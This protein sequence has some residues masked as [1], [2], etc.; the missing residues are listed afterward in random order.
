MAKLARISILFL[1]G[2]GLCLVGALGAGEAKPGEK[3]MTRTMKESQLWTPEELKWADVADL[4]GAKEA[5][6]WGDPKKG[7]YASF[8][9]WPAG[10]EVPL[11]WHTHDNRGTVISG[12]LSIS[13]DGGPA[14]E[15]GPGSYLFVPGGVKHATACKAGAD[16]VFYAHQPGIADLKMVEAAKK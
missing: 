5:V 4:P 16:C 6:V 7:A 13:M 8:N 12:T 15:V 10:T 1:F 14:K 3:K 11:H 9:R 2:A